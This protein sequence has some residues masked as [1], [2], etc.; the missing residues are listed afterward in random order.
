MKKNLLSKLS[1]IQK[2]PDIKSRVFNI[3][4][5]PVLPL[6][7]LISLITIVL[8]LSLTQLSADN[9]YLTILVI[10]FIG[11]PLSFLVGYQV[12]RL[13]QKK[14]KHLENSNISGANLLKYI[15]ILTQ[16][17]NIK[18]SQI[19]TFRDALYDQLYDNAER[20]QVLINEYISLIKDIGLLRDT[21][22][23]QNS[24]GTELNEIVIKNINTFFES[25][26]ITPIIPKTGSAF[27]GR[28]QICI[29]YCKSP[30]TKNSVAKTVREGL[31]IALPSC[32]KY[33]ICPAEVLL[34]DDKKDLTDDDRNN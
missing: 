34:S 32:E 7:L 29:G 19:L 9:F 8:F 26:N 12:F 23:L 2:M 33:L 13:K 25:R 30:L 5:N 27:E 15:E 22:L 11:Y 10:I 17:E 16:T 24:S 1:S 4:N 3:C 14:K 20:Y 28:E 31:K 6:I 18:K 21:L